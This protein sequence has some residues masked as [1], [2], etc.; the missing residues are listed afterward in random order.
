MKLIQW[1]SCPGQNDE[2]ERIPDLEALEM[3][4]AKSQGSVWFF[5]VVLVT[6]SNQMSDCTKKVCSQHSSRAK[7]SLSFVS[8]RKSRKDPCIKQS[9]LFKPGIKEAVLYGKIHLPMVEYGLVRIPH[10]FEIL[11]QMNR[12]WTETI[13]N[14]TS[15]RSGIWSPVFCHFSGNC[16]ALLSKAAN[17]VQVPCPV[18]E[19]ILGHSRR[20]HITQQLCSC[21]CL[22]DL[23]F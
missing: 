9:S 20:P 19:W 12:Q 13:R 23:Y 7:R 10:Y 8:W 22:D 15:L 14:W 3:G 6:L 18:C 17:F 21:N 4:D 16:P 11:L 2:R 5:F 1:L